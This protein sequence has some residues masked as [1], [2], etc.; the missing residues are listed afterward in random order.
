MVS[1]SSVHL[2]MNFS[3]LSVSVFWCV[4]PPVKTRP[5]YVDFPSNSC[6]F[7]TL[8]CYAMGTMRCVNKW[9]QHLPAIAMKKTRPDT[10]QY[11]RER[12]GR[13][14]NANT[15]RNLKK[16]VT[17][18]TDGPTYQPTQTRVSCVIQVIRLMTATTSTIV[19]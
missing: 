5:R 3:K 10:R 13:G 15:A 17:R 6:S 4:C 2:S 9:V 8:H 7:S 18:A 14:G 16:N 12:L 11:S 19:D 1:M